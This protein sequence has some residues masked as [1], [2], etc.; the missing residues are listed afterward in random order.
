VAWPPLNVPVPSVV[1]PSLNVTVPL[2]ALGV[3]VAVKVTLAPKVEGFRLE[4]NV[5]VVAVVEGGGLDRPDVYLPARE[6]GLA[7][8]IN[9]QGRGGGGVSA[10]ADGAGHSGEQG[11]SR[12]TVVGQR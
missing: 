5:V 2:A 1:A 10:V 11:F 6:A 7:A 4:A 3:T 8:L 9:G 12:A